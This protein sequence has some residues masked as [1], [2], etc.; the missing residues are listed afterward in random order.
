MHEGLD[1][2]VRGL[3]ALQG[4]TLVSLLYERSG[5]ERDT[6]TLAVSDAAG[7]THRLRFTGVTGFEAREA[8]PE[9]GWLQILDVSARH[10][11][12]LRVHVTDGEQSE[13]V[14]F[15]ATD[16]EVLAPIAG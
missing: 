10:L 6:V 15:Y 9:V 16:V 1:P 7:R 12:R 13:A 8:F 4:G 3:E 14:E 11:D 2:P 5:G